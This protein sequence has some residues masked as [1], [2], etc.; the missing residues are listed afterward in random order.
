MAGYT[1]HEILTRRSLGHAADVAADELHG[2]S[3]VRAEDAVMV[4]RLR[5]AAIDDGDEVICDDHAVLAFPFG[6]LGDE[7]L[8]DNF[9]VG[10][11]LD[12]AR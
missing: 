1:T 6:T 4:V 5:G 8:F 9:H 10:C 7:G 3:S 11:F 2:I 12:T